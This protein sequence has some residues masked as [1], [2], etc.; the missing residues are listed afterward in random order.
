MSQKR[1]EDTA[2]G[3]NPQGSM[4]G[5]GCAIPPTLIS[6]HS[7]LSTDKMVRTSDDADL[8]DPEACFWA[9]PDALAF[10]KDEERE[11]TEPIQHSQPLSLLRGS[12]P[13]L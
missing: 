11:Y 3:S 13:M 1:N 8:D 9:I 10:K 6:K 5:L 12:L 4:Y 7:A 2:R